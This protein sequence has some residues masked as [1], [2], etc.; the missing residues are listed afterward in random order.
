MGDDSPTMRRRQLGAELRRLREEAGK[1]QEDVQEWTNVPATTISRMEHG[2]RRVPVTFLKAVLP[3]YGVGSPQAE[4][5]E[6]L[7]RESSE[8]GWWA[9]YG[10]TVPDWFASFL[11][12]ETAADELWTYEA[13][14]VPG[15]LQTNR[16]TEATR[17]AMGT[18]SEGSEKLVAVRSARQKRLSGDNPMTFR[19]VLNEAVIRREV[20]G[21]DVMRE[22]LEYLARAAARPNITLQILPFAAGAHPGMLGP[23][24][25]LRFPQEP[26]NTIYIELDG[27]AVYWEKPASVER[28]AATFRRLSELALNEEDTISLISEALRGEI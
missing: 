28:Y 9:A 22:Q 23:F 13:E 10:D 4:A 15:I 11:G 1:T 8:R 12:M 27:G 26:L 21:P 7:A 24:T 2:K 25:A 19:A 18:P 16:Y 6:K 20:G 3:L 5:L 17:A 14:Y